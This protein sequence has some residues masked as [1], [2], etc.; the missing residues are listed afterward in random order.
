MDVD[1]SP[2]GQELVSASYDKTIRI[3]K[4][5]KSNSRLVFILIC[6]NVKIELETKVQP[7]NAELF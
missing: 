5:Y 3:F 1:Y 7:Y 6:Y 2:T 4:C